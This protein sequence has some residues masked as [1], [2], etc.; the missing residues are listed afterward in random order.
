M[1]RTV[2]PPDRPQAPGRIVALDIIRGIAVMGILLG[3]IGIYLQSNGQQ[4]AVHSTAD[5]WLHQVIVLVVDGKF[6]A[7]FALL[8]GASAVLL[9][10]SLA[11][12]G[13]LWAPWLRRMGAL[14]LFGALNMFVFGAPDVLMTYAL[15]GAVLPLFLRL[16]QRAVLVTGVLIAA[17][18]NVIVVGYA[19][20]NHYGQA[21][22]TW[23]SSV[24]LLLALQALGHMLLGMWAQRAQLFTGRH[25]RPRIR[26]ALGVFGLGTLALWAFALLLPQGDLAD[27]LTA[28]LAIVPAG[29]Y[30]LGLVLLL[31]NPRLRARLAPVADYGRMALTSYL[32]HGLLNMT[33]VAALVSSGQVTVVQSVALCVVVWIVQLLFARV[34]M[35]R[36]TYGPVE[37]VWRAVT[38]FRVPALRKTQRVNTALGSSDPG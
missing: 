27:R 33:L 22:L 8:F 20:V 1:S 26:W 3:N 12:R 5:A 11:G 2:E 38:H 35:S 34:W 13:K 36:F 19:L 10:D 24:G 32:T 9:L 28:N 17:A 37:W 18:G 16:P 23:P 6:H 7:L 29:A 30:L 31:D 14:A 25:N 21:A 15:F 4:E